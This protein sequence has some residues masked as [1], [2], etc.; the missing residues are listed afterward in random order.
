MVVAVVGDEPA[1]G[2]VRGEEAVGVRRQR[3]T[4]R[5]RSRATACGWKNFF[6]ASSWNVPGASFSYVMFG[7][8]PAA[9][10]TVRAGSVRPLRP[11]ACPAPP[12]LRA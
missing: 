8:V 10:S 7:V 1:V 4:G 2:V 11:A 12:A 6:F 3:E 5:R 9:T